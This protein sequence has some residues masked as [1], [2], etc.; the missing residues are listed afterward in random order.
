MIHFVTPYGMH[1][2]L[3]PDAVV[4]SSNP[5]PV[6]LDTG[7]E[8]KSRRTGQQVRVIRKEGESRE[9]AISRVK[10]HHGY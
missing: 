3:T 6:G 7:F 4:E 2:T 8:F 1:A 10:A 9:H 5:G